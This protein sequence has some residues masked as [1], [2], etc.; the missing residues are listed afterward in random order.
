MTSLIVAALEELPIHP[1]NTLDLLALIALGLI[2]LGGPLLAA[3]PALLTL[4]RQGKLDSKQKEQGAHISEIRDQVSNSHDTNLR[5]DIDALSRLVTSTVGELT[6]TVG[7]LRS[8]IRE[9]GRDL[10]T[11]RRERIEGDQRR[12]AA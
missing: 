6:E 9:L 5:D 8:D 1:N 3:L 10:S 2:G 4:F 12:D 11:E 7:E